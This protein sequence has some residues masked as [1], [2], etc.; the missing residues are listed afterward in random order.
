MTE[1]ASV[2]PVLR[3]LASSGCL[4]LLLFPAAGTIAWPAGWLF[5]A[6]ITAGGLA[7]ELWL[8]R[9]DPGL[10]AERRA[11]LVR[12]D[13]AAWDRVLMRAMPIL[14]IGWLPF[15]AA[16]A[17]RWRPSSVPAE[18]QV[19][20]AVLLA[21]SFVLVYRTYRA[22]S[23]AAPVVRVQHERGHR[24]VTTGPYRFVRHPIYAGGILSYFGTPLMLGSF[25]GLIMVPVMAVLL[26]ARAMLEERLLL[27]ELEGYGTY[28][29]RVRYRLIP[30]IW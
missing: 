9:Y 23:Y 12:R 13:Q 30:A 21:A 20:G 6:E 22:N 3:A 18:A 7:T 28:V 19:V 1:A 16:D 17:M 4:A 24:V 29:N 11:S 10:L 15:M 14:W 26:G 2:R 8:A 5:L 27:A 25:W